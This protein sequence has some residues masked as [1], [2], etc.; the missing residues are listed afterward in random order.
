MIVFMSTSD[1]IF[2]YN[3]DF[4]HTSD[5]LIALHWEVL[6]IAVIVYVCN[7]DT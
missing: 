2:M 1:I 3:D 4:F 6:Y 5:N 7:G